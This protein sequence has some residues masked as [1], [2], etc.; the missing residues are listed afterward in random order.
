[1][2]GKK[3]GQLVIVE[4]EFDTSRCTELIRIAKK[5]GTKKR[6]HSAEQERE[7]ILRPQEVASQELQ[8]HI[9]AVCEWFPGIAHTSDLVLHQELAY[10]S[11]SPSSNTQSLVLR[12]NL[13]L[14]S[15]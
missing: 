4:P 15:A 13:K 5:L 12:A 11:A 6:V 14:A 7:K 10:D 3:E 8:K 9:N 1:M 2:L